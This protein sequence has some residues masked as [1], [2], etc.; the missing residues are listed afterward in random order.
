MAKI[1]KRTLRWTAS[2]SPQV[3]GY[4]LYWSEGGQ[5][6]YDCPSAKLGNTTEVVLPD[7]V[8]SFAPE[9]GPIEFGISAVDE[10]GNESDLITISAPYQ[11]NVPQ[12]PE[13]IWLEGPDK[14]LPQEPIEQESVEQEYIEE[15]PDS[16]PLSFLE[17]NFDDEEEVRVH[18]IGDG[19]ANT[20]DEQDHQEPQS[21]SFAMGGSHPNAT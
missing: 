19:T 5:V 4:I 10:L 2:E 13:G 8:E 14:S 12:A 21:S 9:S 1:K 17:H 20:D 11:F 7:D 3:V 15:E 18:S 16:G 6:N